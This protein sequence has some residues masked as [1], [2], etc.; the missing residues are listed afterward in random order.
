MCGSFIETISSLSVRV[1]LRLQRR[2]EGLNSKE[3]RSCYK[4][5]AP[6]IDISLLDPVCC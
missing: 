4:Y 6:N 1:Q 2:V 3:I 5:F